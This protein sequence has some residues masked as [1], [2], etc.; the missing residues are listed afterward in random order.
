VNTPVK[1]VASTKQ[2]PQDKT[3]PIKEIRLWSH[4]HL[5]AVLLTVSSLLTCFIGSL[6]YVFVSLD[7]PDITGLKSYRPPVTSFILD[8]EGEVVDRLFEQ[9][10]ILVPYDQM[11]DLLIQAFLAAEDGRFFSH[12]GLDGWSILRAI[13][14]NFKSGSRGQGGSTITQQVAR[15]LL[16][17]PEKTYTRKIKEAILAYRIDSAL[18]KEE[19]LYIYLNQI[20]LGAGA[21]GVEAAARTYFGKSVRELNLAEISLIAGL[22]Q[23]PS[24][25]SPLRHF[26]R[27]KNRQSYVLNRMAED[28][29]I[30][31]TAARNAFKQGL[32]WAPPTRSCQEAGYFLQQVRNYVQHKYGR[33]RLFTEGLIIH[34]SL[35]RQLQKA[36]TRAVEE[37]LAQ[38][39]ERHLNSGKS[40]LPPQAALVAIE[41]NSGRVRAVV[42]G[43][44]FASSQFDRAI[45]ARRQPGSAFKPIIYAAAL[46]HG[47]TPASLIDDA[48]L[49]LRGATPGSFW[50]P[51]NFN[52][53]FQGPTTLR[54][55]LIHSNNVISVRLLQATGIGP[56]RKL[57]GRMGI[58]S[59][60]A[61]NLSIALGSSEVSLLELTAAY[62]VFATG[63]QYQEPIFVTRILD[64]SGRVLEENHSQPQLV[65][66]EDI[67]FQVTHLL[68]GVITEG[69]GRRVR[70]LGIP[71][72]GKTGTT[73]QNMDA[74]FVGY[75]PELITGVWVGYDQKLSLGS[76]ETGSQAAAPIWLAFMQQIRGTLAGRDFSVPEGI[77]F[78]PMNSR[79]GELVGPSGLEE[80]NGIAWA[81]FRKKNIPWR[82]AAKVPVIF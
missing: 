41:A 27:A 71:A 23:A 46:A 19:I 25:Y 22:P 21:H 66:H 82:Q 72:A 33:Q 62:S 40:F 73:D 17:T 68:Q 60:L 69:T 51:R 24:R 32:F 77:T 78:I 43:S 47:Y 58:R 63:G 9:N 35:D 16:L 28:G 13:L 15:A 50:A 3:D 49:R 75:T 67:A 52:G 38:W 7:I 74:W 45:H 1:A 76:K 42:G 30:T 64:A 65:V 70:E 14:Q 29:Y 48:P 10:R 55:G 44:S 11:P 37:G 61:A 54:N 5:I 81:A 79:T 18:S 6:L 8:A 12:D 39:E 56:V 4:L 59:P 36:A 34:T 2:T 57:A 26:D 20:Y 53:K 31:P 80:N